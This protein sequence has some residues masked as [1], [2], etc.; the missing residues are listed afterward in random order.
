MRYLKMDKK[1]I[2][3][4]QLLKKTLTESLWCCSKFSSLQFQYSFFLICLNVTCYS[5]DLPNSPV[6]PDVCVDG[7]D[8]DDLL[9]QRCVLVHTDGEVARRPDEAGGVVV[10]VLI[11]GENKTCMTNMNCGRAHA[12]KVFSSQQ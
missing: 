6:K 5:T 11:E 12:Q 8:A 3:R 1:K 4:P 10:E 9:P 7:L 2:D